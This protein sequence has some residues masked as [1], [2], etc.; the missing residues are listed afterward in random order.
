M[1]SNEPLRIFALTTMLIMCISGCCIL[2]SGDSD[3]VALTET[4][5]DMPLGSYSVEVG[6]TLIIDLVPFMNQND[7]HSSSQGPFAVKEMKLNDSNLPDWITLDYKTTS[8]NISKYDK[9]EAK[10]IL[11][12]TEVTD[13]DYQFTLYVKGMRLNTYNINFKS[14]IH[15]ES[16][17]V[18]EYHVTYDAASGHC[19]KM[20][21]IVREGDSVTLPSTKLDDEHIFDGWYNGSVR[22]GGPGDSFT[23][24]SDVKLTARYNP[25]VT[26]DSQGGRD[27]TVGYEYIYNV[28]TTPSDAI[29]SI[30]GADWLAVN[31][32]RISG[33]PT[34]S[35][36]LTVTVTAYKDGHGSATEKFVIL[37]TEEAASGDKPRINELRYTV[38][39]KDPYRITI[40]VDAQDASSISIDHGDGT[41]GTGAQCT[42]TYDRSGSY[43]IRATAAN[44]QGTTTKAITILIADKS[45][46]TSVMYNNEYSYTLG[47]DTAGLTPKVTGA[48]FLQIKVGSNY[49]N[50]YGTPNSISYVGETYDIR[51]EVGDF[52]QTWRLT[53]VSG[54]TSPIPG[55]DVTKI[56]GLSIEVTDTAQNADVIFYQWTSGGEWEVSNTKVTYHR[57]SEAGIYTITQKVT[58]TIDGKTMTEEYSQTI[59]VREG[60]S[61][62]DGSDDDDKGNPQTK[63]IVGIAVLVIGIVAIIGGLVLGNVYGIAAGVIMAIVGVAV[64]FL[65]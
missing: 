21:D 2:V 29:I 15:I 42:H 50:V 55:F 19:D 34:E 53:V 30:D 47:I 37:V 59:E 43:T 18:K 6:E 57:Y 40:S 64:R 45:P 31:G 56:D 65:I 17:T 62:G 13:G 5:D 60:S 32:H 63:N 24:T 27:A 25:I 9:T 1:S 44:A 28:Q 8:D 10:L 7:P 3:A 35:G 16:F 52:V 11:A 51:L 22:I 58:A 12:P 54:S 20:T 33:T 49:V 48:S 61:G 36:S 26:I 46:G 38:D 41:F 14:T 4:C 23:P 39:S